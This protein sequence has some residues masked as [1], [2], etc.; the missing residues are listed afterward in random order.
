MSRGI[1]IVGGKQNFW[2]ALNS[3]ILKLLLITLFGVF[4]LSSCEASKNGHEYEDIKQASEI[5]HPDYG[6]IS[7]GIA[8]L[9]VFTYLAYKVYA[10]ET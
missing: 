3:A 10:S 8:L 5:G 1:I 7:S 6:L 4:F 9:P 2:I